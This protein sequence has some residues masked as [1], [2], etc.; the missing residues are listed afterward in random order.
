MSL[1]DDELMLCAAYLAL[2]ARTH[3]LLADR[4]SYSRAINGIGELEFISRAISYAPQ[5]EGRWL[6]MSQ[7]ERDDF[8]MVWAYEIV[9]E[10]GIAYARAMLAGREFDADATLDSL[11]G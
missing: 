8:G 2:G 5:V 11:L 4:E 10:F 9:E 7:D 3:L 1:P 6:A